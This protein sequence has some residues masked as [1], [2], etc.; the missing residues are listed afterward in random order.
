MKEGD[1]VVCT[2]ISDFDEEHLTIGKKY[3]ILDILVNKIAIRSDNDKISMFFD[4]SQFIDIQYLR[5]EKINK[6]LK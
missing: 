3:K 4:K 2:S 6:I 5:E 1:I